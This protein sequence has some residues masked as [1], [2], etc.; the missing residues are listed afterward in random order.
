MNLEKEKS[1][2]DKAREDYQ[3]LREF[4]KIKQARLKLKTDSEIL[5]R[6]CN[7]GRQGFFNKLEQVFIS[8]KAIAPFQVNRDLNFG[9]REELLIEWKD[10]DKSTQIKSL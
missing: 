1:K 6:E 9:Y 7:I 3:K 2:L 5:R 4:H 8:L 10:L